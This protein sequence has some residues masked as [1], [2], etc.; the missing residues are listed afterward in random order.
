MPLAFCVL[1][2]DLFL[3]P[4]TSPTHCLKSLSAFVPGLTLPE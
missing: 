3:H 1:P 4:L 2:F